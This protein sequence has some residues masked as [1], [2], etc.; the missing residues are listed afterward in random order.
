MRADQVIAALDEPLTPASKEIDFDVLNGHIGFAAHRALL[1]MRREFMVEVGAPP[2]VFNALV[3]I[4]ANSG[5]TQSEL[6]QALILDKGTAAHLLRDLEKHHWIERKSRSGDRRWKGAY[7]SPSGVRELA[8]LKLRVSEVAK[9]IHPLY[10]DEERALL[11]RL[12]TRAVDHFGAEP[13]DA[14]ED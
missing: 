8:R 4:G 9:R 13:T 11:L 10:T 6:A 1:V 2:K 12:L 7:L 14:S 5:I 3:L